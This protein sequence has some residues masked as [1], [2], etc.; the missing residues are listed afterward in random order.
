ML[1]SNDAATHGSIATLFGNRVRE[2]ICDGLFASAY[3]LIAT[4]QSSYG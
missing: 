2:G 1:V 4:I 3:I